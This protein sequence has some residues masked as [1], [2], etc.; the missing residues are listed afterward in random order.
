MTAA[1]IQN[2]PLL[3]NTD[4]LARMLNISPRSVCNL[5]SSG[6]LGP[7]SFR[8]G[9]RKLYRR[10]EIEKWIA[11]GLKPQRQWAAKGIR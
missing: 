1:I 5:E 6:R 8:L 7:E 9:R 4:E 2:E 3:V 11:D 10:Q